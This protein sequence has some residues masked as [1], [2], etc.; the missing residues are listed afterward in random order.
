MISS[1]ALAVALTVVFA[2][3]GA[4]SLWRYARLSGLPTA[5]PGTSAATGPRLEARAAELL[6]VLMSVAMIAMAW[7]WSGGP[8]SGSGL[9][10]IVVLGLF[11]VGFAAR[12]VTVDSWRAR[13]PRLFHLLTAAAMVW[14]VVT[15]PWLMGG[16]AGSAG[17]S[18]A[19]AGM[20]MPGMDMP[21]TSMPGSSAASGGPAGATTAVP[22]GVVTVTWLFV[23]AMAGWAAIWLVRAAR[24]DRVLRRDGTPW[25]ERMLRRDRS[26]DGTHALMSLGMAAMFVAMI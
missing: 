22:T 23:A 26:V 21:G 9:I 13:M 7:G 4:S 14:M 25:R 20:A 16:R 11:A 5:A 10:Q 3:T 24:R 6:H 8:T 19:T 17:G 18:G 15:M 2:V 12:T 1:P